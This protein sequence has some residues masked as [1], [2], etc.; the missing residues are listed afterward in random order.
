MGKGLDRYTEKSKYNCLG[1]F[2]PAYME[3]GS[4]WGL[5]ALCTMWEL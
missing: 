5:P 2:L 1:G 4:N 3:E